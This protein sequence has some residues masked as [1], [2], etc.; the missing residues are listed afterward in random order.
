MSNHSSAADHQG[1]SPASRLP[2]WVLVGAGLAG[3]V[4]VFSFAPFGLFP[5]AS[6]SIAVLYGLIRGRPAWT[7]FFIGWIFGLGLL[8]V[9]LSWIR[10]SLNE[11]GNLP[12]IAASLLMLLLVAALALF[13]G[14]KA[15]L[16]CR[17]DTDSR[18]PIWVGPILILPSVWVSIE[19]LRS[20]LF[21]G[22]PWLLAGNGQINALP[23][24]GA[25]LAG[26]APLVGV[27][28]LSFAVSLS[29]GLL[30]LVAHV[31]G[32]QRWGALAGLVLLWLGSAGLSRLEW[33]QPLGESIEVAIIQGNVEQALKWT[34][35]ALDPT[36]EL[37]QGMT[38]AQL[39]AGVDLIL[40]PETAIPLFQHQV[41]TDVLDPLQQKAQAMGSE[42][43]IGIPVMDGDGRYY[44]SLISLGSRAD[45]YDKRHLVPFGEY[46]PFKSQL[47]PLIDWFEVP[48][49]DFSP[50][51]G[52]A[53]L[54]Q[55]GTHLVGASICYE[56]IFPE[57][58][59]QALPQAAYLVNVSNDAWFGDSLAAPQHLEFARL[60]ALENGRA[61]LRATNTGISAIID[62]RGRVLSQLPV[63][64]GG[65]LVGQ[66]QPR[67]GM[68]P[69]SR[70][71]GWPILLI[72]FGALALVLIWRAR[73]RT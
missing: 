69:F 54:L 42:L 52:P 61:M 13:Y 23:L 24:I 34:P 3:V 47:A 27:L 8:G 18:L 38:R 71:G 41:Q 1:F 16:I 40:W 39:D 46:L 73:I 51:E 66:I 31:R 50:G 4:L 72:C 35:A 67:A 29:A 10:I 63:F 22:F 37:Y 36:L 20:W 11:F 14:L 49:S 45:R 64:V 26:L 68:T 6:L 30:W 5:V 32:R 43:V 7:G 62:H 2:V 70:A 44:N 17:L 28:G 48:M 33:T 65:A 60:R 57:E 58:V 12:S 55:V 19:W 25:P 59:R 21:T 53:P 9:G 56:D 15:W